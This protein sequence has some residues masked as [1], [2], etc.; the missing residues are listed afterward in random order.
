MKR[1]M[2]HKFLGILAVVGSFL[3][4][5]IPNEGCFIFLYEPEVPAKLIKR[6]K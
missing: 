2:I 1:L 3:A 4:N 6:R 5:V